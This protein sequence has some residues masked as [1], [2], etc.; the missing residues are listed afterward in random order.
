M[1]GVLIGAMLSIYINVPV[2]TMFEEAADNARVASQAIYSEPVEI[3]Q[4]SDSRVKI[5]TPDGYQGWVSNNTLI[6][7]EMEY[8]ENPSVTLARVNRWA[9]HLYS[10]QDTEYGPI[11][12]LPFESRLEVVDELGDRNGRW[13][14]VKLLDGTLAYIQRGDVLLN[15][16]PISLNDALKFCENF[17]DLPYTWGGRSSFGYDCSGFTQMVYRLMGFSI[18]RDSKDQ[19]AWSGFKDVPLEELQAGDLIFF[20]PSETRVTHVGMIIGIDSNSKTA[21]FMHATSRQLQPY[22]RISNLDEPDWNG[23]GTPKI[24]GA[25]RLIQGS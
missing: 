5:Q 15:P 18:P 11:L 8:P 1:I 6:K 19:F 3:L 7:K 10:V 14:Q 12:T 16:K 20:G 2:A 17:L 24:C 22:L 13:L 21:S 25:R 23:K 9:A 4:E